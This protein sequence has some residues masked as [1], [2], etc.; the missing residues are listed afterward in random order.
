MSEIKVKKEELEVVDGRVVID[1]DT[2]K[3]VLEGMNIL[4][5]SLD[6][7]EG[8]NAITVSITIG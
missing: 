5:D 1:S 8:A 2:L 7:E 4:G 3:E 6:G